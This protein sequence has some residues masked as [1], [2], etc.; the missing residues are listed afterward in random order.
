MVLTADGEFAYRRKD[1]AETPCGDELVRLTISGWMRRPFQLLVTRID[2][3]VSVL[4]DGRPVPC[5]FRN[6]TASVELPA[7]ASGRLTL[8][9][10]EHDERK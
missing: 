3:P 4:L 6:R 10:V 7:G 8:R 2:G 1:G 9:P 5:R